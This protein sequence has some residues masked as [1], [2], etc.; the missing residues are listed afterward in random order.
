M[1]D[2]HQRFMELVKRLVHLEV[3]LRVVEQDR[4]HFSSLKMG[5]VW[6]SLSEKVIDAIA[7]D[8]AQIRKELRQMDGKILQV[9]QEKHGR[10]VDYV[11]QGYQHEITFLNEWMKVECEELL[12]RYLNPDPREGGRV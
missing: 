4:R 3:L 10:R 8:M 5:K 1:D 6:H 11:Y 7:Y 2:G 9:K 12:K